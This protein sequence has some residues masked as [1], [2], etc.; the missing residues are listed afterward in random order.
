MANRWDLLVHRIHEVSEMGL[1]EFCTKHLFSNYTA[2]KYRRKTGNLKPSEIIYLS[3]YTGE[4]VA[5]L[6]GKDFLSMMLEQG[7]PEM[8]QV[9]VEMLLRASPEERQRLIGLLGIEGDRLVLDPVEARN[10]SVSK[11]LG[12]ESKKAKTRPDSKALAHPGPAVSEE[13]IFDDTY[14]GVITR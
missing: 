1:V 4:T 12:L 3:W 14:K 8:E 9:L 10:R 5:D 6:F 11:S 2:F 7:A 13:D